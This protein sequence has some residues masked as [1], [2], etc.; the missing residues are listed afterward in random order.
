MERFIFPAI[1]PL[2][3]VIAW[4]VA[5]G[6]ASKIKN[7]GG[8]PERFLFVG[9]LMML[10]S[11][12]INLGVKIVDPLVVEKIVQNGNSLKS[13]AWITTAI[14]I[15]AQILALVGIIILVMAFWKKFRTS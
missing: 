14:A 6:I 12:L 4:I 9:I 11:A 1:I 8:K 3:G 2:F 10:I 15:P 13:I 7:K 5:L